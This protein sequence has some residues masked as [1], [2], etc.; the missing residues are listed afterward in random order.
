[1]LQVIGSHTR[2]P[3]LQSTKESVAA[4]GWRLHHLWCKVVRR[5][6]DRVRAIGSELGTAHVLKPGCQITRPY[7]IMMLGRVGIQ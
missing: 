2:S 7:S 1:M 5:T 6:S 4:L 3:T